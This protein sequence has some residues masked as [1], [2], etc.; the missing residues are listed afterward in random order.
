MPVEQFEPVMRREWSPVKLEDEAIPPWL[1]G[2]P[3]DVLDSV[4]ASGT[5]SV[6][7]PLADYTVPSGEL[8]GGIDVYRHAPDDPYDLNK[9]WYAVIAM[10]DSDSMLLIPG[11]IRDSEHWLNEIPGRLHGAEVLAVPPKESEQDMGQ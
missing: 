10:P 7:L 9:D 3:H 1:R 6:G 8:I 11:P 4:Y 2:I 5:A